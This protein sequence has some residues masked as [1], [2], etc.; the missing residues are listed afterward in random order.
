MI[1]SAGSC[2]SQARGAQKAPPSGPPPPP[3][4]HHPQQQHQTKSARSR[5]QQV[6]CDITL[7]P[8]PHSHFTFDGSV[9]PLSG[10]ESVWEIMQQKNIFKYKYK[11]YDNNK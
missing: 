5:T 1:L 6:R 7:A 4:P 9:V 10:T 11:I 3:A 8:P 2:S